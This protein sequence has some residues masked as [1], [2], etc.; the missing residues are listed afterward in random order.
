MEVIYHD[1]LTYILLR[2]PDNVHK[3][4]IIKADKKFSHPEM[5]ITFTEIAS[6][7]ILY[8]AP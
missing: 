7:D 1:L 8:L 6:E 2:C 5:K 3:A 4:N